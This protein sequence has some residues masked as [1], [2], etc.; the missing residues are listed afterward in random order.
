MAPMMLQIFLMYPVYD[1]SIALLQSAIFRH[2]PSV[3]FAVLFVHGVTSLGPNLQQPGL[4]QQAP[5]SLIVTRM[6]QIE[7]QAHARNE[8]FSYLSEERSTR[9]GDHLWREKVVEAGDG[10][11]RRLLA[12]DNRPLS[13]A[14]AAAEDRRIDGLVA[15]PEALQ[16]LN[17]KQEEDETHAAQLLKLLPKAFLF[18]PDGTE[19][20]CTRFAFRPNPKFQPSTYEE[21]V[22]HVLE[23]TISIEEPENRL[24]RLDATISQSV[25]FGFGL[26]GKVDSSGHFSIQRTQIDADVWK[27]SYISVHIEG[28]IFLLKSFSRDQEVRR[29]DI[30]LVP[31]HLSLSDTA[32]LS[33][34]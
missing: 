11:L 18:S 21:R 14:E 1:F 7:E 22:I 9:T 3:I 24:C 19:Q 8:H 12:I 31:P 26:L 23:E 29:S 28:R 34:P 27:T 20:G 15:D 4:P 10:I 30:V 33:R 5:A 13:P 32:K 16:A 2:V 6:A 17:E 25:E